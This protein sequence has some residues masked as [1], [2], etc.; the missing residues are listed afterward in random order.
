M[1][2]PARDDKVMSVT[3]KLKV[4]K[5]AVPLKAGAG[6]KAD[7]PSQYARAQHTHLDNPFHIIIS[8]YYF[9]T[10]ELLITCDTFDFYLFVSGFLHV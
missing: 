8:Q 6:G 4:T 5:A 7:K 10:L 3:L 9:Y 2:C 1:V